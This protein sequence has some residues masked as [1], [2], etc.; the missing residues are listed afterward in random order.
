MNQLYSKYLD[1]YKTNCNSK[2]LNER[3]EKFF[4]PSQ[5]KI[6]GSKKQ[7]SEWTG[8]NTERE[9]QKPLWFEINKKRI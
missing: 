2:D 5:L 9:L 3:D 4:E 1:S 6:P 7:K 8:E